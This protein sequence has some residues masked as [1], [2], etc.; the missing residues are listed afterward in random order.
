MR[1]TSSSSLNS[2]S[3]FSTLVAAKQSCDQMIV[4]T[5]HHCSGRTDRRTRLGWNRAYLGRESRRA[6]RRHGWE[7][8]RRHSD[9]LVLFTNKRPASNHWC[10]DGVHVVLVARSGRRPDRLGRVLNL[11]S[12]KVEK[13]ISR[14]DASC[15]DA[16]KHSN[17]VGSSVMIQAHALGSEA[18]HQVR[19]FVECTIVKASA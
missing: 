5:L 3:A 13:C 16:C 6:L 18:S 9:V 8:N 11:S 14:S 1:V 7:A 4:V 10:E 19:S 15:D 12:V 2:R 17:V